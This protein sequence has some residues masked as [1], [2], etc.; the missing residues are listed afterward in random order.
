MHQGYLPKILWITSSAKTQNI[1]TTK[2]ESLRLKTTSRR[3][4]P[5]L[6]ISTYA[7]LEKICPKNS[8]FQQL[9]GRSDRLNII[10][11]KEINHNLNKQ[12]FLGAVRPRYWLPI[13]NLPTWCPCDERFDT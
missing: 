13:P 1:S 4:G 8:M 2:K 10:L 9:V 12:Q 5:N 11:I 7:E 3:G 6:K